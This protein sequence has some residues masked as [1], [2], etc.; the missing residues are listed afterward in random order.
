MENPQA[1]PL[2]FRCAARGLKDNARVG[3]A[4]AVGAIGSGHKRSSTK[5]TNGTM[6]CDHQVQLGLASYINCPNK[7]HMQYSYNG[8]SRKEYG[9]RWGL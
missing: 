3:D 2:P 7:G 9:E 5:V 1:R 8:L 6:D 4:A